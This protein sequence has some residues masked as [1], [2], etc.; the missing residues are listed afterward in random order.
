VRLTVALVFTLQGSPSD[1][2]FGADKMKH[3]FVAAFTQSVAYSALRA[4]SL[5]H[6]SSLLGATALSVG[7][8]VA[9]EM[10]DRRT[11]GF[12]A[13]DL[14]WDAAGIAASTAL[15]DRIQR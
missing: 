10:A 7:S 1:G 2:W 15:L 5:D 14:A 12:S 4:T 9:K 8:S 11:T 6:R 13:R 3:F